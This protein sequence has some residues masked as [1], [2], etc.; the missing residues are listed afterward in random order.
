M[1]T[2]LMTPIKLILQVSSSSPHQN[3]IHPTAAPACF[4]QPWTHACRADG[5][6]KTGWKVLSRPPPPTP[7]TA[8]LGLMSPCYASACSL[9]ALSL[10]FPSSSSFPAPRPT[11]P[12]SSINPFLFSSSSLNP[13][14]SAHL[15]SPRCA[16][17]PRT[18]LTGLLAICG[19]ISS[20]HF[21]LSCRRRLSLRAHFSSSRVKT[22]NSQQDFSS[23]KHIVTRS[24]NN[25]VH[26]RV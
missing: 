5:E 6:M 3:E 26:V 1:L 22:H 14:V 16:S 7:Q 23:N 2:L 15:P 19:L 12:S 18:P 25:L 21:V 17:S 13:L 11:L 10:C 20:S 4:T 9:L 8:T 24:Q